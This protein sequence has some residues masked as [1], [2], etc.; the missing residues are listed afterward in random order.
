MFGSEFITKAAII[1]TA[2]GFK[3]VRAQP[4]LVGLGQVFAT[5]RVLAN[6]VLDRGTKPVALGGVRCASLVPHR[7][8]QVEARDAA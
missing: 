4:F 8:V 5:A 6:E 3:I 1:Q 7:C 2:D